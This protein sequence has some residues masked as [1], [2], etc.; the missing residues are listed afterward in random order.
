[1]FLIPIYRSEFVVYAANFLIFQNIKIFLENE[2]VNFLRGC[3]Q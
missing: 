1:M 3:K 2:T